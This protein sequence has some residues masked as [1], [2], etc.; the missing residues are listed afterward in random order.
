MGAH[1]W[2]DGLG[3]FVSVVEGDG[4]DVVVQNVGLDD[5]VEEMTA[6]ETEFTVD[7]CCG[8]TGEGPG[9][10]VVVRKR[11]VGVLKVGNGDCKFVSSRNKNIRF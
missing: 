9:V 2:L 4:A 8:T 3:S 5:A 6:D 10:G 11:G 1:D 7:R